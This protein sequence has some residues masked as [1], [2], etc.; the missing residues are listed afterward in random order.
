MISLFFAAITNF[1][2]GLSTYL[3]AI[4]AS[5]LLHNLLLSHI[6]RW[7]V[8]TFDI[9]PSGR[10]VNRF[11]G[12]VDVIDNAL[13]QNIKSSLSTLATV[14]AELSFDYGLYIS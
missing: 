10:L 12:D 9:T 11:G 13:I 6:L 4:K 5:V 3:G 14:G 2:F 1:C 8:S 7:S